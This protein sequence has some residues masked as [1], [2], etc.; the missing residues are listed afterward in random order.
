MRWRHRRTG[1]RRHQSLTP[2]PSNDWALVSDDNDQNG[3]GIDDGVNLAINVI[4]TGIEIASLFGNDAINQPDPTPD[5]NGGGG[6]F[7]GGGASSDW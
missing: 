2:I 4:T 5:F 1:E 3:N 6:D 7:G